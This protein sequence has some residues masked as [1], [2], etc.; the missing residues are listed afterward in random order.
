VSAASLRGAGSFA[1]DVFE[2]FDRTRL[3][4][5]LHYLIGA[6]EEIWHTLRRTAYSINIKERGDCSSAIFE[7]AGE[8]LAIPL[9]GIA[10]RQGSLG[11]LIA[12]L[13][14]R[15][16]AARSGRATS[17]TTPARARSGQATSMRR[18]APTTT[19]CGACQS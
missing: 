18:S 3:E 8:T 10:I 4:V 19:A 14:V 12:E 2:S 9:N 17:R 13:L 15:R 5:F 7:A 16:D 1:Q 6:S 11:G